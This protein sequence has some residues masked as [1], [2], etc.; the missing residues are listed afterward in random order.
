MPSPL[1]A[2]ARAAARATVVA[3]RAGQYAGRAAAGRRREGGR[4]AVVVGRFGQ[5]EAAELVEHNRFGRRPGRDD[6]GCLND[7][8][9]DGVWICCGC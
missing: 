8:L 5:L 4:G 6:G 7:R 1:A 2:A 3:L 9:N